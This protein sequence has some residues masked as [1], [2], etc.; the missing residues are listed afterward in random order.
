MKSLAFR[1]LALVGLTALAACGGGSNT[2][3]LPASGTVP[4]A[5]QSDV[6][7]S[8]ASPLP[9]DDAVCLSL[10]SSVQGD[11]VLG[12]R[13]PLS[14]S[15]TPA[16]YGPAVLQA[17]YS[18]SPA[19]GAGQTVAIVD[20]YD[21]PTVEAD[22]GVYRAQYGLPPCTTANGCFKKLS[23]GGNQ[24][25]YPAA[26]AGWAEEISLDVDMVSAI[27]PNC[28]IVLVEA[29]TATM[30]NLGYAVDTAVANK[31]T[32]VSNSYGGSEYA[33]G[34]PNYNHPGVVI[35]AA[36]G[37]DGY[38]P[39]QPASFATV[40]AAGGTTLSKSSSA[41]GFTETAWSDGGSGCSARVAKPSWQD[42]ANPGC[43]NRAESDA[44]ADANPNTGVAVYD[45]TPYC[46]YG[47]RGSCYSGWLVF[48][49]TSVASPLLASV[50]ALAGNAA[51][52]SE[53]Q[54]LWTNAGASMYDVTSGSNGRCSKAYT[55][56]C[57]AAAGYDGPTGWGTPN[58]TGAF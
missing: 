22:L 40:V 58:G 30:Q 45:S 25:N 52:V 51:T 31:A 36:A 24:G 26:N 49:G 2:A 55:D 9:G 8:C 15:V 18:L 19:G 37:D 12:T 28:N 13:T 3:A 5:T 33:A 34:D 20:A 42:T 11:A 39:L 38:G 53:P 23:Q 32:V 56:L 43:P 50:F 10:L 41:R 7:A 44:S 4:A 27:C 17:A 14:S 54:G 29:T 1:I 57:N 46:P 35:V 6:V 48:G 21:D 16:G 47:S